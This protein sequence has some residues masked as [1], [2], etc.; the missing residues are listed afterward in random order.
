MNYTLTENGGIEA[1]LENGSIMFLPPEHNG[2]PEWRQYQEWL[3]EGNT[4]NPYVKPGY[5]TLSSA[6]AT[7]INEINQQAYSRLVDSDWMIVR[8]T[9][10]GIP[11]SEEW[12]TYR[13]AIRAEAN[14][15]V[16][17]INACKT[18]AAVMAVSAHWVERP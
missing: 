7:K 17:Q 6:K 15:V 4:P 5:E 16:S 10:I 9:E 3:D 11:V 12:E 8:S 14:N 13:A 18:V 1:E 2:T